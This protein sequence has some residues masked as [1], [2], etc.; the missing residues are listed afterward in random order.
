MSKIPWVRLCPEGIKCFRCG[1][2]EPVTSPN[3][4]AAIAIQ[5]QTFQQSHAACKPSS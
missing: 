5:M 4:Q 3:D 2:A 1:T